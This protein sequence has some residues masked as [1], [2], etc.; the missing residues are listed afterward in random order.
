MLLSILISACIP[1]RLSLRRSTPA[2]WS[3]ASAR[4]RR[5]RRLLLLRI[6]VHVYRSLLMVASS[7]ICF[8]MG[9]LLPL[10]IPSR[11]PFCASLPLRI[12]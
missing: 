11:V 10:Q 4:G 8:G 5:R 7:G 2:S 1:F 3:A 9:P 12:R 6:E